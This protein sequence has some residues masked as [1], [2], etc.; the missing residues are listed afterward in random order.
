V[1]WSDAADGLWHDWKIWTTELSAPFTGEFGHT[2]RFRARVWQKYPNGAHLVSP[3]RE[4]GDTATRVGAELRGWVL[5]PEGQGIMGATIGIL[6]TEYEAIS[7][8][9]GQVVLALPALEG[10]QAMTVEHPAW[11][12]PPPVYGLD[13]GLTGS[14]VLTWTL[15]PADDVVVNGG[16]EEG[17]QGWQVASGSASAVADPV[18]SGTGA[19]ALGGSTSN[20]LSQTVQLQGA[21]EPALSFWYRPEGLGDDASFD[22]VLTVVSPDLSATTP[23]TETPTALST[24]AVCLPPLDAGDW[25][26]FWCYPGPRDA[27][28]TAT[29]TVEFR[30]AG[31]AEDSA[32][33][34]LDEVSLGATPGGPFKAFLPLVARANP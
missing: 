31:E 32:V 17:L 2:Y 26:H 21:W 7:G 4:E 9:G 16:F 8:P 5:G 20:S 11:L 15:R 25:Q 33:V 24:Q 29:V 30:L 6:G 23:D 12:A 34:V 19:V 14:L 27:P 18:H 1:Q 3:Y 10:P 13:F 28:L 22:V